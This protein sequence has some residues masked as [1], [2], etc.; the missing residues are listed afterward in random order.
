[1]IGLR[2]SED[3]VHRCQVGVEVLELTSGESFSLKNNLILGLTGLY[4]VVHPFDTCKQE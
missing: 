2:L 1:M 4:D 3:E